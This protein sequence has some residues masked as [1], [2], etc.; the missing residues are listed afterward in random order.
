MVKY[1]K[2][3]TKDFKILEANHSYLTKVV[4]LSNEQLASYVPVLQAPLQLIRTRYAFLKHLGRVQF[5]VTKPNFISIKHMIEPDE[6]KFMTKYAKCSR[7]EY[8]DFLKTI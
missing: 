1:P 5:D 7:Q 2:L 4:K 3:F 8:E 6:E